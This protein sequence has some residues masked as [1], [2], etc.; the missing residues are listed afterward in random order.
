MLINST[1]VCHFQIS[2]RHRAA[3]SRNQASAISCGHPATFI[4][5][6]Y[7]FAQLISI[8]SF[9]RSDVRG[10]RT[11]A[12]NSA[13]RGLLLRREQVDSYNFISHGNWII[14]I[15]TLTLSRCCERQLGWS[16]LY[17]RIWSWI[18]IGA[19]KSFDKH[20]TDSGSMLID[21]FR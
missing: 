5:S 10:I 18:I 21:K 13:P 15:S 20:N 7:C 17:R 12:P 11:T 9:V 8:D 16:E 6:N 3:L 2:L 19:V 14:S 4:F 1:Q